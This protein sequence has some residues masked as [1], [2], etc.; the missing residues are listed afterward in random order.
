MN[1]L[2]VVYQCCFS[3][4]VLVYFSILH[5]RYQAGKVTDE[6]LSLPKFPLIAVGLLEALAAASGM[7]AGGN[8]LMIYLWHMFI[9]LLVLDVGN[10]DPSNHFSNATYSTEGFAVTLGQ[11][12]LKTHDHDFS[13]FGRQLKELQFINA[14]PCIFVSIYTHIHIYINVYSF[15]FSDR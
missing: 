5:F 11:L 10:Y 2:I 6:M 3:R 13:K 1:L 15:K 9:F 7:A 14:Y 4:Y 12:I 8:A